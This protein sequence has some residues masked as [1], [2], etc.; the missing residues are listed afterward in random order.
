MVGIR[1]YHYIKIADETKDI[2]LFT[3]LP[4]EPTDRLTI[5]ISHHQLE[6]RDRRPW[7][8]GLLSRAELQN[9]LPE[10]WT[11]HECIDNRYIFVRLGALDQVRVSWSHPNEEFDRSLYLATEVP[12]A[13]EYE[14][15]SYTWA[16]GGDKGRCRGLFYERISGKQ[17]RISP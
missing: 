8:V 6:A 14:A 12:S 15:L 9:T 1:E 13:L 17:I 16:L 3:I 11:V 7:N 5:S 10:G 2:G 4:G